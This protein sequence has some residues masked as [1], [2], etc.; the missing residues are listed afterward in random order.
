MRILTSPS[1]PHRLRQQQVGLLLHLIPL[2]TRLL[3]TLEWQEV[4]YGKRRVL[5][6]SLTELCEAA[7]VARI[8]AKS[9]RKAPAEREPTN[10]PDL[11]F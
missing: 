4:P 7:L 11:R 6:T 9:D 2:V 3:R 1:P 5:D 8:H 10:A